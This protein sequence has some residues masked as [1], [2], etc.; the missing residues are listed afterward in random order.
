MKAITYS[1]A[2]RNLRT[3]IQDVCDNSE[4]T[5]IIND[6]NDE[7]AV[8]IS[9]RDYQNIEET[10]Y[11]LRSPANRA[12]LKKSLENVR[13]GKLVSYPVEVL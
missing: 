13:E 8:L 12:H 9:L 1:K 6:K 10:A 2:Q 11:L 5:I 3:I 4:P 7:Q